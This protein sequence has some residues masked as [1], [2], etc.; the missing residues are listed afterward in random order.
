MKYLAETCFT[1]K[2]LNECGKRLSEIWGESYERFKHDFVCDFYHRKNSGAFRRHCR[3][4]R[5]E[6][7]GKK[8]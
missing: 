8:A 3:K 2:N 7:N 4:E 6:Q 1:C 5:R